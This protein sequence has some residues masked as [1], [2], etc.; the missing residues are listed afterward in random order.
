M[1]IDGLCTER[2]TWQQ[3]APG[4]E[5]TLL[6]PHPNPGAVNRQVWGSAG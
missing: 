4:L 1:H 5:V 3:F 6:H 2:E